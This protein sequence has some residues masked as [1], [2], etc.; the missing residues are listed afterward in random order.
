MH[1]VVVCPLI[2]SELCRVVTHGATTQEDQIEVE[3]AVWKYNSEVFRINKDRHTVSPSLHHQ[4]H[5][6]CKGRRRAYYHHLSDGIHLTD[7]LKG[8]WAAEFV[9]IVS[10]SPKSKFK[11]SHIIL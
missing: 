10:E 2:A 11:H 4:V 1:N 5:R 8:K 6:Y 9:Q 7:Y 3:E